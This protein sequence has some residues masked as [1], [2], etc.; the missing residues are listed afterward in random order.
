MFPVLTVNNWRY[1]C[2]T[3][4]EYSISENYAWKLVHI[5]NI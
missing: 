2:F 3:E 4:P 5:T 1:D